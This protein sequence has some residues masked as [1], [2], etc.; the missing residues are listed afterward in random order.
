MVCYPAGEE[1][2]IRA[3]SDGSWKRI[4][5]PKRD[6][7]T[8]ELYHLEASPDEAPDPAAVHPER[9]RLL[10]REIDAFWQNRSPAA[11]ADSEMIER[12]RALGYAE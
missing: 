3:I 10:E 11:A 4:V 7:R 2:K 5:T 6:G 9:V 8:A 12:L 1:G